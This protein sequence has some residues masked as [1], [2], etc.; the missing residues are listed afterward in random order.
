MLVLVDVDSRAGY[1]KG[2]PA[3]IPVA[4]VCPG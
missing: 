2:K 3:A 1:S 4:E